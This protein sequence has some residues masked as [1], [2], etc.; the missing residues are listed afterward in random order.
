MRGR[1]HRELTAR[2]EQ[3]A[4]EF[5]REYG[6]APND[7]SREIQKLQQ[8][9]QQLERRLRRLEQNRPSQNREDG[10]PR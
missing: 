8:R 2:L 1:R 7:Q 4:A 10:T 3:G 5:G 6:V 9:I